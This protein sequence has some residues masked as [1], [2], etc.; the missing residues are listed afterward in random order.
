MT[1]TRYLI[2]SRCIPLLTTLATI[3]SAPTIAWCL[4]Y[5]TPTDNGLGCW[6]FMRTLW[7]EREILR[8]LCGRVLAWGKVGGH[9]FLPYGEGVTRRGSGHRL[10]YSGGNRR[11]GGLCVRSLLLR[12]W[13]GAQHLPPD[14]S[15]AMPG[16]I[17][18]GMR[19]L[20][21]MLSRRA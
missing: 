2:L 6:C 18:A 20:G 5:S 19:R 21:G 3:I 9:I 10:P 1:L 7:R 4:V 8:L 14:F 11:E 13:I 12:R 16:Y 15:N 17:E